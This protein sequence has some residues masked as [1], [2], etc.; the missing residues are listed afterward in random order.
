MPTV[1]G[2]VRCVDRVGGVGW[3]N[4]VCDGVWLFG[5]YSFK[6]CPLTTGIPDPFGTEKTWNRNL[7]RKVPSPCTIPL[8]IRARPQRMCCAAHRLCALDFGWRD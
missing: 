8:Q 2:N 6:E 4:G 1:W 5:K 3:C 7:D